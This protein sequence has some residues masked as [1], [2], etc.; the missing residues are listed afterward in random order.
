VQ[1]ERR[2]K[3]YNALKLSALLRSWLAI[4]PIAICRSFLE[5][6]NFISAERCTPNEALSSDDLRDDDEGMLRRV[7]IE[8][9]IDSSRLNTRRDVGEAR[10]VHNAPL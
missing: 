2:I 7:S 8:E 9:K 6:E 4:F 10:D 1:A 3:L 5:K